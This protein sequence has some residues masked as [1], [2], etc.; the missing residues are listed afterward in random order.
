ML[1]IV[2]LRPGTDW[3]MVIFGDL[4]LV[5]APLFAAAACAVAYRRVAGSARY[6]WALIGAGMAAWMLGQL[7]WCYYELIKGW[8]MPYPSLADVFYLLALPLMIAGMLALFT[9]RRGTVRALLDAFIV[10][11]SLL[12]VS[13]ALLIGP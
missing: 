8:V 12:F 6:G 4:A 2:A 1:L 9:A 7:I 13:W 3:S 11:A 10:G 5:A